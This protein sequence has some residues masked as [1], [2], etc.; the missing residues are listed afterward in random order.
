MTR[1]SSWQRPLTALAGG[2][3][4]ALLTRL[5]VDSGRGALFARD[6]AAA[7]GFPVDTTTDIDHPWFVVLIAMGAAWTIWLCLELRS[8]VHQFALLAAALA[9]CLTGS[10]LAHIGGGAFPT[11]PVMAALCLAFIF[12]QFAAGFG[13]SPRQQALLDLLDGKFDPSRARA[14]AIAADEP[15]PDEARD[16]LVTAI[17]IPAADA[18]FFSVLRRG[19][20]TDGAFLQQREDGLWLAIHGLWDDLD[21][22]IA[23]AG[24][25]RAAD[26]LLSHPAGWKL[27]TMRGTLRRLLDLGESPSLHL[28]GRV[29]GELAVVLDEAESTDDGLPLW[30]A[31][32]LPPADASIGWQAGGESPPPYR[33]K[34]AG[35]KG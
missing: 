21:E 3:L 24:L 20:L 34:P 29:T 6:L 5:L 13:G 10:W 8:I 19:L 4:V 27:A 33:L 17:E 1:A 18:A 22:N 25:A 32:D 15:A 2:T 31:M 26:S 30:L 16:C 14:L 11:V 12:G 9:L 35:S 7:I 28:R 23:W